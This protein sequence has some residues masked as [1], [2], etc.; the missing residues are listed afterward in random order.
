MIEGDTTKYNVCLG[1]KK[2]CDVGD[3]DESR[4]P[5]EIFET[6]EASGFSRVTHKS[7][8][9]QLFDE[10]YKEQKEMNPYKM[11]DYFLS[12]MEIVAQQQVQEAVEHIQKEIRDRWQEYNP[13]RH[14]DTGED[15]IDYMI[16]HFEDVISTLKSKGL[17]DK[18]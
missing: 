13:A 3:P 12:R 7:I 14:G 15:G 5:S 4:T 11:R 10:W 18:E 1:C 16:S 6:P 17:V 9:E 2:P 8:E